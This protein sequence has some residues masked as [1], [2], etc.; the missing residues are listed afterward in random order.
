MMCKFYL[1]IIFKNFI[2]FYF[3]IV[4]N[5]FLLESFAQL[6]GQWWI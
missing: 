5:N 1:E 2:E 3:S 6:Y 4:N